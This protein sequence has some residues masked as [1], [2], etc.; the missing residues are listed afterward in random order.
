VLRN[1]RM[2]SG[3]AI[4][5]LRQTPLGQPP[6]SFIH[7]LHIVVVFGPVIANEQHLNSPF[8]SWSA[9]KRNTAT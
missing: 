3:H 7:H 1:Q 2:E 4:D 5:T 6:V 8:P 9:R